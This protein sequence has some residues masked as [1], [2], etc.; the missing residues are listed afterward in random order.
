MSIHNKITVGLVE[1][2]NEDSCIAVA[3]WIAI[4]DVGDQL[5][6]GDNDYIVVDRGWGVC[7]S[8]KPVWDSQCVT[9]ILRKRENNSPPKYQHSTHMNAA[10][11]QLEISLQTLETNGPINRAE[12]NIEQADAEAVN[13]NEIRYALAVLRAIED[14][15]PKPSA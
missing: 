9:L 2:G 7:Y 14:G 11:A 5:S 10:I 13:A 15:K 3:N 4:P 12:G 6:T 8:G 1:E